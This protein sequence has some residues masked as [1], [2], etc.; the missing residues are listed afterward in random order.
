MAAAVGLRVERVRE[1]LQQ[2]DRIAG[3]MEAKKHFNRILFEAGRLLQAEAKRRV[4][5]GATRG[6]GTHLRDAIFLM[7]NRAGILSAFAPASAL[8]G[9]ALGRRGR[10]SGG[11][12]HAHLVEWGTKERRPKKK[13]VMFGNRWMRVPQFWGR[14]V[15]GAPAQP[16]FVPALRATRRAMVARIENGLKDLINRLTQ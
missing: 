11:A 2:L 12:P 9:V 3:A 6:S 4:A 1:L 10:Y 8:A 7:R 13:R 5:Y 16:Y 15:R 14:R